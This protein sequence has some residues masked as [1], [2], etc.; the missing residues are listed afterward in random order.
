M[1]K[2]SPK[3]VKMILQVALLDPEFLK[4]LV[5]DE[6]YYIASL[7]NYGIMSFGFSAQEAVRLA[8]DI[9]LELLSRN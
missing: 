4:Q 6:L 2:P 8:T 7:S 9:N 1:K 5:L 3:T